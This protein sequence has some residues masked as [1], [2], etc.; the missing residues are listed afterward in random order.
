M[1]ADVLEEAPGRIGGSNPGS[2]GGPEV[3]GIVLASAGTGI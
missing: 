3:A 2:D 1:A